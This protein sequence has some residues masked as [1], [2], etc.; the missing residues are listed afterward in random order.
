ME[1]KID[2]LSDP[3]IEAFL[4]EHVSEMKS[5]SPPE[6]KHALDIDG[7][8]QA[9]VTFYCTWAADDLIACAALKDLGGKHVEIKSMR[10]TSMARGKGVAKA[11]LKHLLSEARNGGFKR[12][13]LETGSMAFFEPARR[14]YETFGFSYC[15][16]FADYVEDPNSVFMSLDLRSCSQSPQP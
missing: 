10:V 3:R 15:A 11:L 1:I 4:E 13:K 5:V 7:L 14:L 6:S 16:P 8:R 2:D 12:V 9:D